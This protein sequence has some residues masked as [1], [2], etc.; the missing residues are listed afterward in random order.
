LAFRIC[1]IGC[2]GL[3][4]R[5]HGPSCQRYAR[6]HA[7]VELAACCDLDK[8]RAET[9]RATF[10]FG[11]AYT[12]FRAM[13][14]AERP[15]AVCLMAPVDRTCELSCAVMEMGFPLLMEKPPG[16][17]RAECLRMIAAADATG[18]PNQVAFNRRYAPLVR[19]LKEALSDGFADE[20]IQYLRYDFFRIDRRDADFSTTA[21]HGID[22]VSYLAGAPYRRI[23]FRYQDLPALGPH[24]AN[25]YLECEMASGA[26]TYLDFCPVTG[27]LVERATVAL[28][29]H[30]Y[31]LHTPIWG[32]FDSPG[33]LQH[34]KRGDLVEDVDGGQ[35]E[36]ADEMYI[37]SGFYG[38][39]ASF[40]DDLRAGRRPAGDLCSGLQSVEIAD[41]LRQR[42]A[43]YVAPE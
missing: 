15:D 30:T 21:I 39:N 19:K 4:T 40:F 2:G 28:Y 18:V 38:E 11:Q 17:N 34:V 25:L 26:T 32:A 22:T 12:D 9:Y 31:F 24:V 35:L 14:T 3:S 6:R 23:R 7:D 29:D 1:V 43:E 41:C 33:R 27:V 36:G 13:L 37:A 5:A 8:E 20:D 16:L 42:S 10:G